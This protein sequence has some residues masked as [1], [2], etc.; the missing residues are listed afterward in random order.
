[1]N[2]IGTSR[3]RYFD[4]RK[5]H[6]I[7]TPPAISNWLREVIE[8]DLKNVNVVFDPACGSGNLLNPFKDKTTI[9]CDV[10]DFSPEIDTFIQ[11]DFL[12]WK[13]GKY[14][15]D[16]VI[17][18]PP[19][20]HTRESARKWGRSTLFPEMFADKVFELFGKD[21]K[22]ILFT[23]MGLRLN[24]RCYSKKQ[25]S[26]YRNIRDN[27]GPITSIVSLPLDVFP[28][29][30]FDPENQIGYKGQK[31]K[32]G[33]GVLTK[34]NIKR[35]ET[36]QEILFFNMPKL[37]PHYCLPESVIKDLRQMDKEAWDET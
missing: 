32:Q 6:T 23:P 34:S 30:D 24:T 26:R 7:F 15:T 18:N 20:N 29:P 10:E 22:M 25:G 17:A 4:S 1:M 13:P 12:E 14:E 27:W 21:V 36:Q 9:G 28:N 5:S 3:N 19:Y 8:P 35:K 2:A 33:S 16:L 37:N 11:E 31:I